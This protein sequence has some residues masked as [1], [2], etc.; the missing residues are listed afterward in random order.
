MLN[1]FIPHK[2]IMSELASPQPARVRKILSVPAGSIES[3]ASGAVSESLRKLTVSGQRFT[4]RKQPPSAVYR[5]EGYNSLN[6]V[7][8]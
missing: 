3:E 1:L 8:W 5:N 6:S 7:S 2:K 4:F